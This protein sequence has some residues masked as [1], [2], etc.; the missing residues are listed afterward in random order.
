VTTIQGIKS[1]PSSI[2][3]AQVKQATKL[4]LSLTIVSVFRYVAFLHE[5]FPQSNW[6]AI[7][8]VF[9]MSP[10]LGSSLRTSMNRLLGSVL[11]CVYG[12]FA[13]SVR[14]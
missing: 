11:A 2:Q 1:W 6:M 7:T 4:A 3:A 5:A 8:I 9:V 13:V 10:D 14:V 12:I